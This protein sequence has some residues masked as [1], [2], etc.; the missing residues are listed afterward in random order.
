MVSLHLL[1]EKKERAWCLYTCWE[2]RRE[3]G[4]F[5]PVGREEGESMVS[6]H[7]LGEEERAR[8]LYTCWERRREHGV[9]TPVFIG[10]YLHIGMPTAI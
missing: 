8:C 7:L 2:R 9:F 1:G 5:T 3:H 6:V 4:V 10:R